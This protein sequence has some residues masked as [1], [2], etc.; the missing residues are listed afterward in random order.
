MRSAGAGCAREHE[1]ARKA[2]GQAEIK[3]H[4]GRVEVCMDMNKQQPTS[5]EIGEFRLCFVERDK[6]R[7]AEWTRI[8]TPGFTKG[9]K[10]LIL[11]TFV[12]TSSTA[13]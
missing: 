4:K 13:F 12:A 10:S 2:G 8:V 3:A 6:K 11:A 7:E 9:F 1:E 5:S